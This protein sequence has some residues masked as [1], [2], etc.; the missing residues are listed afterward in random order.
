MT[1]T[2]AQRLDALQIT[3]PDEAPPV[4][5]GYVPVFV[6]WVRTGNLL[7]LSGRLAKKD[8]QLW[9]GKLGDQVSSAE[10][11]Q[12]AREIAIEMLATLRA[13]LGDLEN[14]ARIVRLLVMVNCTPDFTE[15]HVVANGAS[16]LFMEVF[17]ER[18]AHARSAIGIASA[19][20]GACVEMDLI[21]EVSEGVAA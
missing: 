14:V 3:L 12:A 20:F 13:A 2:I 6:P 1:T 10:G 17:A 5:P 16:E 4:V 8:G 19:P 9:I 11:K 18:G 21:V 15:P 7:Y